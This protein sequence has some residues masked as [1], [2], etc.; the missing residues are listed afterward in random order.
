MYRQVKHYTTHTSKKDTKPTYDTYLVESVATHLDPECT[1]IVRY[2][3][4]DSVQLEKKIKKP[5]P[6]KKNFYNYYYMRSQQNEFT[7]Y[8]YD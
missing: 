3:D 8:Q 5:K 1:Q 7:G 2:I 6:I 4:K